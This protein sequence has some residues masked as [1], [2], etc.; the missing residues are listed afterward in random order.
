MR[1]C[2]VIHPAIVPVIPSDV[3]G[4]LG[5]DLYGVLLGSLEDSGG[6]GRALAGVAGRNKRVRVAYGLSGTRVRQCH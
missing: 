5:G 6:L 4:A 1:F 3:Y 2:L